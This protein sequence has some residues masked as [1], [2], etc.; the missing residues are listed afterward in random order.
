MS[1]VV[2]FSKIVKINKDFFEI[3]ANFKAKA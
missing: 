3:R 2:L 1:I